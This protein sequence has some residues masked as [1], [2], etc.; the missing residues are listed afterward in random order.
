ML[1]GELVQ[2]QE[3]RTY[4]HCQKCRRGFKHPKTIPYGP[5]CAKVVAQNAK[6]WDM[7]EEG[8]RDRGLS[9]AGTSYLTKAT[10]ICEEAKK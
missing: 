9:D 4:S 2:D 3:T 5:K 8:Y 6:R 1:E 7:W 10:C